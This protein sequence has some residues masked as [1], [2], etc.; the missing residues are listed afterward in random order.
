M[1]AMNSISAISKELRDALVSSGLKQQ[2]LRDAAGVSRQTLANALSGRQ[3][4]KLSTLLSLAD[5]LGLELLLL[6]KDAA[7]GLQPAQSSAVVASVV[8]L[9]RERLVSGTPRGADS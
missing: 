7:R 8:D 9:A 5:K 4:F 1:L 6:P 2:A 3:D